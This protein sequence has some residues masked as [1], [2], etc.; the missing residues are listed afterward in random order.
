MIGRRSQDGKLADLLRREEEEDSR[1]RVK[2]LVSNRGNPQ[3]Q[4]SKTGWSKA[5]SQSEDGAIQRDESRARKWLRDNPREASKR[6]AAGRV[7]EL[8]YLP[9]SVAQR[10][11]AGAGG[12]KVSSEQPPTAGKSA[13][14]IRRQG[15]F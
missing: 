5:C 13:E 14:F 15:Y 12:D 9:I 7:A 4:P 2:E 8:F 3:N 1:K 10:L 6:G 11:V